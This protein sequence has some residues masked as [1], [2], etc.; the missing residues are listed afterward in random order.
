MNLFIDRRFEVIREGASTMLLNAKLN[1]TAQRMPWEEAVH[2]CE[3]VT[4]GMATTGSTTSPFEIFYGEKPKT[5]GSF[6]GFERIG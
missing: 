1:N 2:M 5:I 6:S 4:N 3:C